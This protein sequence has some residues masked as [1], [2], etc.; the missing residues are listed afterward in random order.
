MN[1]PMR[2]MHKL[3]EETNQRLSNMKPDEVK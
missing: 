3:E 1:K 2:S